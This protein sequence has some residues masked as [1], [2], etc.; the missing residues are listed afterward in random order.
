MRLAAYE[1]SIYSRAD[2]VLSVH[3]AFPRFMFELAAEVDELVVLGRLDPEPGRSH[4]ALPD[5]AEFVALPFYASLT[6]PLDVL[7]AIAGTLR[8]FWAV[9]GRVDAIWLNGPSPVALA[10][11]PLAALRRRRIV[12]GVRQNTVEYARSRHPGNLP[13]QA[14][15]RALEVAWRLAARFAGVTAVGDEIAGLYRRSRGVHALSVSLVAE[16][17]IAGPEVAAARDY[18]GEIRVLSVG[19]L[20]TEKNP[21]LLADVLRGLVDGGG[22]W[23]LQV[24]GEGGL[25]DDLRERLD[26]LAVGHL[27]ELLGYVPFDAGLEDL[28]RAAHVFLHVSWTE[29]LPQVLLEAFGAR[30]PVAATDV[31]G[32]RALAEAAAVLV[33]PGDA[34]A[35]AA[36]VRA[37]AEDAALRERLVAAGLDRVRE[38]TSEAEVRRLAAFIAGC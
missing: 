9:L 35:A 22:S 21:L 29:G 2:G 18:G 10:I 28:Y 13:A 34:G 26:A 30:L 12:L 7:K 33:R 16:R 14:A 6:Q 11:V 5:T 20:E 8:R 1:D 32:V 15:L 4:Y 25:A 37:L 27:A 23:R 36:A 19:R 17:S 38:R 31:G 24:V 3:Q